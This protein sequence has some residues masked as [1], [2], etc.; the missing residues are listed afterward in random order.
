MGAGADA[1]PRG[2]AGVVAGVGAVPGVD[3]AGA[4]A[5]GRAGTGPPAAAAAGF[6]ASAATCVC[7]NCGFFFD[8]ADIHHVAPATAN[9]AMTSNAGATSLLES[10][11]G[12]AFTMRVRSG[13]ATLLR[14]EYSEFNSD[15]DSPTASA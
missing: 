2:G 5:A 7:D 12:G 3:A 13:C 11:A 9:T 10:L 4:D 14:S 1:D 8:N 6:G 15:P